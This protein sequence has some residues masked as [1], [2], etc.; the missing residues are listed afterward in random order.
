MRQSSTSLLPI[1]H[2]RGRRLLMS[3]LLA[4]CTALTM[5]LAH[6]QPNSKDPDEATLRGDM[7]NGD[8]VFL[9]SAGG[10]IVRDR[11]IGKLGQRRFQKPALRE[12]AASLEKKS[13]ALYRD[14][15]DYAERHKTNLPLDMSEVSRRLVDRVA[16]SKGATFD[17]DM[18]RTVRA[19]LEEQVRVFTDSAET[20]EH[21]EVAALARRAAD[22]RRT[23]L[24]ALDKVAPRS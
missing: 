14:M 20:A 17:R 13:D 22:D 9:R 10:L 7:S 1:G 8:R 18:V 16:E 5:P 12:W 2:Q 19:L 15:T 4:G 21:Q 3:A 6:A 11:E 24:Q 23:L